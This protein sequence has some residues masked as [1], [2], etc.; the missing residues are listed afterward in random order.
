MQYA[1]AIT[2]GLATGRLPGMV[3]GTRTAVM[4]QQVD[5]RAKCGSTEIPENDIV[6]CRDTVFPVWAM[7]LDK[8]HAYTMTWKGDTFDVD[9][10]I[11]LMSENKTFIL[12]EI[13][14]TFPGDTVAN[15][16]SFGLSSGLYDPPAGTVAAV[17]PDIDSRPYIWVPSTGSVVLGFSLGAA[18]TGT[19]TAEVRVVFEVATGPNGIPSEQELEFVE[20]LAP[21]A[22]TVGLKISGTIFNGRGR[23]GCWVRPKRVVIRHAS[24]AASGRAAAAWTPYL[25]MAVF[26][27][28]TGNITLGPTTTTGILPDI[29]VPLID[30]AVAIYRPCLNLDSNRSQLT[31]AGSMISVSN[32]CI[33][34]CLTIQ[35]TTS[36]M[37]L[38]GDM[39]CVGF[40]DGTK[41]SIADPPGLPYIA[42]IDP[43][44]KLTCKL[45]ATVTG[46]A[47]PG[48]EIMRF[49]DSRFEYTN[50]LGASI[51][52]SVMNLYKVMNYSMFSCRDEGLSTPTSLLLTLRLALEF[53]TTD[54]LLNPQFGR[55]TMNDLQIAVN[56]THSMPPFRVLSVQNGLLQAQTN[57]QPRQG[58]RT[59]GGSRNQQVKPKETKPKS[60]GKGG[61][62]PPPRPASAPKPAAKKA[63]ATKQAYKRPW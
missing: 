38:E 43:R 33:G 55:G 8:A 34:S 48:S 2:T 12:D 14:F 22:S 49:Q 54:V 60:G 32:R 45:G 42:Q 31:T 10:I 46:F 17:M 11:V 63:A 24:G 28:A 37:N 59:N 62:G 35:N 30:S 39:L 5:L 15:P 6:L 18:L 53:H 9:S 16:W 4:Q 56:R 1:K 29:D 21:L 44:E 25:T 40:I 27:L 19:F 58:P 7:G 57:R 41:G 47:R 3:G 13:G 26:N 36:V 52:V 61:R 50:P 23:Y 51:Y 20:L